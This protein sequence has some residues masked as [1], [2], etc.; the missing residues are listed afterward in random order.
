MAGAFEAAAE[1]SK[2]YTFV[3]RLIL[4]ALAILVLVRCV[5]S[6]FAEKHESEVW[7]YLSLPNGGRIDLHHWENI[8][9][10]AKSSDVY[11]EY[12]T[13]SRSHAALI[14][15]AKGSWTVYDLASK[16]G[17]LLNGKKVEDSAP[18]KEGD[19]LNL[20]GVDTV[21]IPVSTEE[22]RMQAETRT[23]PGRVIRPAATFA[24]LMEFQF[25]LMVQLCVSTNNGF[26]IAVPISFLLLM[27][28][29][30]MYYLF[31]RALSRI[32]FEVETAAFFLCTLSMSVTASSAPSSL[33]KQLAAMVMGIFLFLALGW[34]LRDLN[35]AKKLRWPIAGAG[36]ALLAVNLL[37]A[38]TVFGAQNWLSI[39]GISIQPSEFVKI[40][41]VFAGAATLDRLFAKRNL[42]LFIGFAGACV[43]ALAIMSDFGTALIFF[44]SYLVVAY[45]RSGDFATI[46]LSGAGAGFAGFLA[47]MVKP[48]IKSRFATWTKAW[49]YVN[50]GGYQQTRTMA[51]AASGGLFGVG[52]GNG[53]L[54]NIFA[55]NTDMVFGVV[56]EEL[57]LLIAVTAILFVAFLA[58]CSIQSAALGR[59]SFYVIAAC[60]AASIFVFQTSLN[61]LGC[62]DIM[63]FT[64][65]TFPFVSTGGSSMMACWGLLAF[66]KAADTRQNASFIV[67]LP[68][69][70]RRKAGGRV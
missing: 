64:G 56:S 48:H 39:G 65:V 68:K 12:P 62:V 3:V 15:D 35:R 27:A 19:I 49:D 63:P 25:L 36:L 57:G 55:A 2:Y 60:A 43:G 58:V 59:S 44:V 7:G 18:V 10:R 9:G 24:I 28:F 29:E 31:M 14:R 38:K 21:L 51:A 45:L 20:G 5:K 30:W 4:P 17:I 67:K 13:L 52:A 69:R 23:R 42:L 16:G 11:L 32:G 53:W 34:F 26:Q 70:I 46:F 40:C 47:V 54:Q 22:E 33:Y 1:Y 61:V 8:I 41:F 37:A 6:F 66:I 50:D